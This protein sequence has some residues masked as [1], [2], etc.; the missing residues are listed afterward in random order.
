[1]GTT[2]CALHL[3][4]SI[5]L[6]IET[7][8]PQR[9][10]LVSPA[11][12]RST[13]DYHDGTRVKQPAAN[14]SLAEKGTRKRTASCAAPKLTL[15]NCWL[16]LFLM[17]DRGACDVIRGGELLQ[18][19]NSVINQVFTD[20]HLSGWGVLRSREIMKEEAYCGGASGQLAC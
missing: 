15:A 3:S 16:I 8:N 18:F 19:D 13:K 4:I 14:S 1:M 12:S 7:L 17:S 11:A 5:S 6:V 2:H 20:P 9:V 10:R